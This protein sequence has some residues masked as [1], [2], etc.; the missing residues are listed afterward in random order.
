MPMVLRKKQKQEKAFI[1]MP[2]S[3]SNPLAINGEKEENTAVAPALLEANSDLEC[4]E[5]GAFFS[6]T[7]EAARSSSTI[8]GRGKCDVN[9]GLAPDGAAVAPAPV[10][11]VSR[12]RGGTDDESDVEDSRCLPCSSSSGGDPPVVSARGPPSGFPG[13]G[14]SVATAAPFAAAAVTP[15]GQKAQ[16]PTGSIRV[17]CPYVH[18]N[19][20]RC[21]VTF[22]TTDGFKPSNLMKFNT[23][24]QQNKGHLKSE[25]PPLAALW[26]P[27]DWGT[28]CPFPGCTKRL[29]TRF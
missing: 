4:A 22:P 9:P 13:V 16:F 20:K 5:G 26:L 2:P 19:G 15:Q 1:A 3:S 8:S 27:E 12:L 18:A 6:G 21:T 17:T 28:S 14:G 23:H 24:V 7:A 11:I 29:S 10:H 25:V